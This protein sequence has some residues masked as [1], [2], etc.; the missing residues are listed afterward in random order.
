[1]ETVRS[2]FLSSLG[3]PPEKA[4]RLGMTIRT[5]LVTLTWR[6]RRHGRSPG[7]RREQGT[8]MIRGV[9][10]LLREPRAPLKLG[11]IELAELEAGQ[12]LVR[13]AGT[14]IC[15]TDLSAA[16]GMIPLPLP[17]VLGHEGAG[18]VEAIGP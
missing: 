17:A 8:F 12:I 18:V 2:Q 7:I 5:F 4:A 6:K 13:V 9:A 1:G 3:P 16:A 14:G 15:H 10:A 11:E